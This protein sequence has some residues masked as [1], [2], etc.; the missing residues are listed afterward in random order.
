MAGAGQAY[1]K[2]IPLAA[3][4]H[5]IDENNI[6]ILLGW[7]NIVLF[8]GLGGYRTTPLADSCPFEHGSAR[9]LRAHHLYSL[10]LLATKRVVVLRADLDQRVDNLQR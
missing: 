7:P 8:P 6:S 5:K 10:P 2:I 3:G 4:V 9:W 1:E